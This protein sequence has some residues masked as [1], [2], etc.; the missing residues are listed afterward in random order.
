MKTKNIVELGIFVVLV[1]MSIPASAQTMGLDTNLVIPKNNSMTVD[2]LINPINL[3]NTMIAIATINFDPNVLRVDNVTSYQFPT[4]NYNT[5]AGILKIEAYNQFGAY[6]TSRISI[7]FTTASTS[8]PGDI[9]PLIITNPMLMSTYGGQL[10]PEITNNRNATVVEAPRITMAHFTIP[11]GGYVDVPILLVMPKFD[12][13]TQPIKIINIAG[14]D[15]NITYNSSVIKPL[16]VNQPSFAGAT[17]INNSGVIRI[18]GANV[19]GVTTDTQIAIIRF[20]ANTSV[21]AVSKNTIKINSVMDYNQA[22]IVVDTFAGTGKVV[23]NPLPTIT[24]PTILPLKTGDVNGNG[25]LDVGDVLFS[26]QG[27]AKLRFLNPNQTASAD[28]NHDG[29]FDIRD[30]LFIAQAVAGMRTL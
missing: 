14:V 29:L 18:V 2:L 11:A 8:K 19:F 5:E 12:T 3:A 9:S 30:V 16:N 6:D 20:A 28:A 15:L 27:I 10:A 4:L 25:A 21:S 17:N 24:P 22:P 13:I 26:A 23:A 1:L 7:K